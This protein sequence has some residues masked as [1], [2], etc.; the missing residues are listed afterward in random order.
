[1]EFVHQ[2]EMTTEGKLVIDT[3]LAAIEEAEKDTT[4]DSLNRL[5]GPV[6]HFYAN[7]VKLNM[8]TPTGWLESYPNAAAA[9]LRDIKY[10]EEQAEQ[11]R[12]KAE[13]VSSIAESLEQL[14]LA[15]AEQKSEADSLR[16]ELDAIKAEPK[17]KAKK[18][19]D[20]EPEE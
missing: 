15:L 3:M 18:Q 10:F 4:P 16:A 20:P 6:K 8:L 13:R 12:L 11:E 17:A 9:V 2:G 5:S 7:S 14:K 19:A 1:M